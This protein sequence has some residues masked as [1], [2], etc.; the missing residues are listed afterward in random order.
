[1]RIAYFTD[2]YSPEVNGVT[3]TLSKLGSYLD[4]RH[5]RQLVIA[6]DY[7]GNNPNCD[8]VFRRANLFSVRG[9][10]FPREKPRHVAS[11]RLRN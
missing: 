6:P 4:E 5:V 3:N 8:S 2:T 1:M 9:S 7:D 11:C 10:A